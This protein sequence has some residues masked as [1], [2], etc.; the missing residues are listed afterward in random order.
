MTESIPAEPSADPMG[1]RLW[2]G[3][4]AG[5]R[6]VFIVLLLA[7]GLSLLVKTFLVQPFHIPSGSMEDTLIKDDRVV[8]SKL[9]PGPFALA[10]GDIVVFTDPDHWLGDIPAP[11]RSPLKSALIFLGVAP[12]DS[13]EH[14][15]KRVI[16]LPGD[17]VTC[18]TTDGQVSVNDVPITEPYVKPGDT[19]GGGRPAF[20]IVVPAGKVWVMG[21]HRSDSADSRLHDDGSGTTGSVPI[22]AIQGKAIAIVWPFDRWSGLATPDG[23]FVQVPAVSGMSSPGVPPAAPSGLPTSP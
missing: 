9:T 12:D 16:G 8:V 3:V 14:L 1:N 23:V 7:M 10:R 5:V 11:S 18:C 21:D 19:P 15:I 13:H 17:H 20:D 2:R 22:D 4:W 6:E